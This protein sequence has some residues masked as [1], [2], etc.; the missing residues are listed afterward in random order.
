MNRRGPRGLKGPSWKWL[1]KFLSVRVSVQALQLHYQC[2]HFIQSRYS[3]CAGADGV[4]HQAAI[5]AVEYAFG[6]TS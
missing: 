3:Q 4:L 2:H 5:T 6:D 1:L